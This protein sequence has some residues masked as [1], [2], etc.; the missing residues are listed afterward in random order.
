MSF[1]Y[2]ECFKMLLLLTRLWFQYKK[3]SSKGKRLRPAWWQRNLSVHDCSFTCQISS[4]RV[5]TL[6]MG[7]VYVVDVSLP[8]TPINTDQLKFSNK[9]SELARANRVDWSTFTTLLSGVK[10]ARL[11]IERSVFE[12]W[13]GTLCRVLGQDTLFS[14]CLSPPK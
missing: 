6:R 7:K 13:P 1:R 2:T 8:Q 14:Q 4:S 9:G 11:W 12:P 10:C 5:H 3:A